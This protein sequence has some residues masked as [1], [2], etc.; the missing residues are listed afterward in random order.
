MNDKHT[1]V[2]GQVV[3]VKRHFG[4]VKVS[5]PVPGTVYFDQQSF[6]D[7]RHADLYFSG[8][9]VDDRVILDIA[10]KPGS[11]EY[12]ALSVRRE[13]YVR[14]R[15]DEL[16]SHFV[17]EEGVVIVVNDSHGFVRLSKFLK[18]TA[19]FQKSDLEAYM[20]KEIV[21]LRDVLAIG[22]KLRFS[23]VRN[24]D[25]RAKCKWVIENVHLVDGIPRGNKQP[26]ARPA[27]PNAGEAGTDKL[28]GGHG[29]V[30]EVFLD[31]AT[32]KC[33]PHQS[34]IAFLHASVVEKCLEADIDDLR[35]V[36]EV[37]R[38]VR[39]DADANGQRDGRGKWSV[40]RLECLGPK[41]RTASSSTHSS[42]GSR[43]V[44]NG[45]RT[46]G[47]VTEPAGVDS[48]ERKEEVKQLCDDDEIRNGDWAVARGEENGWGEG[49]QDRYLVND[50][51]FPPLGQSATADKQQP[52]VKPL[53]EPFVEAPVEPLAEPLVSIHQ[54]VPA[55]VASVTG[56][57]VE[58]YVK[59]LGRTRTVRFSL[60]NFYRNGLLNLSDGLGTGDAVKLD[61]M[62]GVTG[63]GDEVVHCD[64]AWQGKKPRDVP[65][66]GA[67]DML[68]RLDVVSPASVVQDAVGADD[69]GF[70]HEMIH[71][72]DELDALLDDSFDTAPE[73]SARPEELESGRCSRTSSPPVP[74]AQ[75]RASS[76]A[77]CAQG[78]AF[79]DTLQFLLTEN[80]VP[81]F[82]R[83][84]V[85]QLAAAP[86]HHRVHLRHASTQTEF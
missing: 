42:S 48:R 52:V 26:V 82:A 29:R 63:D 6:E 9:R 14:P 73:E 84:I 2:K 39:F 21:T 4:F 83:M 66:M 74:N 30:L 79:R 13:G 75:S 49:E 19:S 25:E 46:M 24:P 64:L 10:K 59:E 86:G 65:T 7:N 17:D 34:D 60:G 41:S 57:S 44:A 68:A 43:D 15:T 77:D 70:L 31:H 40:T 35:D 81:S 71:D 54:D 50:E 3:N 23:A 11:S 61:Y 1:N 5:R 8:L 47:D 45:P 20:G 55:V 51:E 53:L 85:E 27:K 32:V 12:R 72:D 58:C 62:V 38:R 76:P 37:G 28:V 56:S 16:P 22:V 80:L 33:G 69:D 18:V 78:D 36:L 67:E